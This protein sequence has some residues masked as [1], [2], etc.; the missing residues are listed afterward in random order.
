MDF[1]K[2]Q[3]SFLKQF[4]FN[5]KKKKKKKKE[6]GRKRDRKTVPNLQHEKHHFLKTELL[7]K[8]KTC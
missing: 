7:K 3:R 6:K 2:Q 8:K 4:F 1:F 5:R